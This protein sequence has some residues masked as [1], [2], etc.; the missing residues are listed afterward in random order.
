MPFSASTAGGYRGLNSS[1]LSH[2]MPLKALILQVINVI[3]KMYFSKPEENLLI[4]C[5]LMLQ[6][7][8]SILFFF[9]DA[10]HL[11]CRWGL[12]LRSDSFE[13]IQGSL[14]PVLP[15]SFIFF[16]LWRE[17][18]EKCRQHKSKS[19]KNVKYK[20]VELKGS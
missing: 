20:C 15:F 16:S 17:T 7:R 18:V 3:C 5:Q 12:Q 1:G 8:F 10:P 19:S 9:L 11:A 2:V 4:F 14:S 6:E 13:E